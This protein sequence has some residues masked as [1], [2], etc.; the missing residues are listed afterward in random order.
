MGHVFSKYI[1]WGTYSGHVR[2]K[3]MYL[4]GTYMWD[5]NVTNMYMYMG[6]VCETCIS[7]M[8]LENT[9]YGTPK[10]EIFVTTTSMGY[11]FATCIF[12]FMLSP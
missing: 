4:Y 1:I 3:Y 5:M 6:H 8:H 2:D 10:C 9:L 7:D 12:H 11:I